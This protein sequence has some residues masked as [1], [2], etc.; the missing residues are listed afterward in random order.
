MPLTLRAGIPG[1]F[2]PFACRETDGLLHGHDIDLLEMLAQKAGFSVEWVETD[3]SSLSAG[4]GRDFD[5]A[6]GGVTITPERAASGRFLPGY[7]PFW[8]TGIVRR[9]DLSRFSGPETL[10][11]PDVVVIKNPGG[12]N[13]LWVDANL[14]HACIKLD[15]D[16]VAIP[17][18]IASGEGDLMITDVTEAKHY[19]ERDERLAVLPFALTP[20]EF[21][22][23]WVA[24]D[25]GLHDRLVCAWRRLHQ[26]GILS[27]LSQ[28]YGL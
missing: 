22:G 15:A 21:K 13:E 12:T 8:K 3:W 5:V 25:A 10:D 17:G 2:R 20:I 7:A 1:D 16:N 11:K 23:V 27:M 9:E 4:L 19:A 26:E 18:R 24:D 28:R 6:A 14:R